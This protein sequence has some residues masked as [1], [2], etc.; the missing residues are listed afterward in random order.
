MRGASQGLLGH[1]S[2]RGEFAQVQG[3]KFVAA[4]NETEWTALWQLVG[5]P[6][7]GPLPERLMALGVFLGARSS[8]GH[9]VDITRIGVERSLGQRDMLVVEYREIKPAGVATA[10]L[11]S[12]YTIVLVDRTEA[13]VRYVRQGS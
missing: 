6:A 11:T 10:A 9:S 3:Q 7:P 8:G 13:P 4:R 5:E 2:W 1:G 12:P